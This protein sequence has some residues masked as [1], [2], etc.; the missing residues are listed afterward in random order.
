[1]A[2]MSMTGYG[3]GQARGGGAIVTA[4][5][6]AVNRKQLDVHWSLP[7]GLQSHAPRFN[8][9]AAEVVRRGRITGEIVVQWSAAVR[10]RR[11]A[12]DM[13]RARG[14]RDAF[15]QAARRLSL[16]D[17]PSAEFIFSMPG[18]WLDDERPEDRDLV[19]NLS[20]RALKLALKRLNTMRRREGAALQND[21]VERLRLLEQWMRDIERRAPTLSR[22]YRERLLDH[23]RE[24]QLQGTPEGDDSIRREIA[25][26]AERS[27]ITEEITRFRSHIEQGLRMVR[28]KDASGRS[29]DF[30]AQELFR[31][32]QTVGSKAHDVDVSRRVIDCKSELDKIREQLQNIE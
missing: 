12:V 4:E 18:V 27:D 30:L 22:K 1:M 32:I 13:D 21:L 14:Y 31:E 19:R 6:Q 24:L 3:S 15:R 16:T 7:R 5:V 25:L 29:L 17:E 11:V 8:E 28:A 23:V 2:L 10:R 20:E 9:L 26:Y